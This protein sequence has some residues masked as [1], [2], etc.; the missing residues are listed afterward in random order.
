MARCLSAKC[1]IL[2][3]SWIVGNLQYGPLRCIAR[4]EIGKN[5]NNYFSSPKNYKYVTMVSFLYKIINY[6]S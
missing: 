1:S 5:L 6:S 2:I 4:K 3:G